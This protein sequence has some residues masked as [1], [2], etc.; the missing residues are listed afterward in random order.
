MK[1]LDEGSV[2]ELLIDFT[3][4]WNAGDLEGACKIYA[5]DAS[6]VSSLGVLHGK[7]AILLHYKS[8]YN[9][10]SIVRRLSLHLLEFRPANTPSNLPISM[11]TTLLRWQLGEDS[12]TTGFSMVAYEMRQ[13]EISIVQDASFEWEGKGQ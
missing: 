11:A 7:N 2:R 10:Q 9:T 6:Y 12:T 3:E 13:G 1:T 8:A 5:E 4:K